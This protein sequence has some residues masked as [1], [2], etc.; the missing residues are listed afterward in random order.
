MNKKSQVIIEP[1]ISD[2]R[3]GVHVTWT[4]TVK[5]KAHE[6]GRLSCYIPFYELY[7]HA[8]NFDALREKARSFTRLFFDHLIKHSSKNGMKSLVLHLHKLGFRT[9]NDTFVVKQLINK[10]AVAAN[11]KSQIRETSP[12]FMGANVINEEAEMEAAF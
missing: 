3:R 1:M 7:F 2:G 12:E 5:Y 11:F 8:R 9:A 10:K 6:D 4:Y